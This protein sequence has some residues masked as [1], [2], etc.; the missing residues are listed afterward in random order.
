[1]KMVNKTY[2]KKLH[3]ILKKEEEIKETSM[4][5][6]KQ[7]VRLSKRVI[8]ALHKND[9]KNSKKFLDEL[10]KAFD[11]IKTMQT[12]YKN[13]VH[14]HSF[15]M[16]EQEFAEAA[17]Y[18]NYLKNARLL[19]HDK[20][21]VSVKSY[22]HGIVDLGGELLRKA[23]YVASKGDYDSI[24][25]IRKFLDELYMNLLGLEIRENDIRKKMDSFKYFL[26][27]LDDILFDIKI[28]GK[29]IS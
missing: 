16:A 11:D 18:Y 10:K 17:L 21:K 4:Q 14:D 29:E 3:N 5:K 2:F 27:K 12:K 22:L 28:R 8:Y 9:I 26:N 6:S 13:K 19:T 20:L 25:K 24:H 15:R 1:M 23:V 7:V